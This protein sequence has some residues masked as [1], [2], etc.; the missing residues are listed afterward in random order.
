[1]EIVQE[2]LATQF[3]R[4]VTMSA[5]ATKAVVRESRDI[6]MSLAAYL[7]PLSRPS[8]ARLSEA[9]RPKPLRPAD[10]LGIGAVVH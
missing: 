10:E 8:D 2:R 5:P 1:M 3:S 6:A 9:N 4:L 7:R